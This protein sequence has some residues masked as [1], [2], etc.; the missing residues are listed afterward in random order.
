MKHDKDRKAAQEALAELASNPSKM[1]SAI[2]EA[3]IG[4][5]CVFGIHQA[6]RCDAAE[7][8]VMRGPAMCRMA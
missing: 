3:Q 7:T 4:Q 1:A 2:A 8:D 6:S 5:V